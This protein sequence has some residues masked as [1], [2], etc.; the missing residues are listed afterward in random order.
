[1][2][3][4]HHK[5]DLSLL[6]RRHNPSTA[7]SSSLSPTIPTLESPATFQA[8]PVRTVSETTMIQRNKLD[9]LTA[10]P[11]VSIEET[12]DDGSMAPKLSR[13]VSADPASVDVVC[14]NVEEEP[15]RLTKSQYFE[16]IF[17]TRGREL[18]PRDRIGQDSVI[19]VEIKLSKMVED[20][21]SLAS[22]ISSRLAHI[23]QKPESSMMVTVQQD[24]CI[25]FGLLKG[26]AYL[27]KVYALPHLIAS[28]TNLRNTIFIQSALRDLLQIEPNRGVVLYLPVPEENFATNGTTYMGEIARHE[29][30]TDD[31][32][33]GILR[34]ISRSLSRRL[35]SSSTHS[36]PHSEATTS[37]WN[38]DAD[39]QP[40][41]CR[42]A[43]D[44]LTSDGSHEAEASNQG[45]V[46]EP[47]S[48]RHFLSRRV[49]NPYGAIGDK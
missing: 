20:D 35:K 49:H 18:P 26:P 13:G 5:L 45:T 14:K 40:S 8:L 37:S 46:K 17:N 39:A 48:L 19:V 1:M 10:R 28:I 38:P 31:D 44:S 15:V 11:P 32:D 2:V 3:S 23:Y 7:S 34:N 33:P 24:A 16:D 29:R 9:R 43:K 25:R 41:T 42:R 4:G 12:D 21:A 36:T 27:L 47:K 30:R 6:R 22:M